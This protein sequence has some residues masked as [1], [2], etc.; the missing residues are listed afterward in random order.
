MPLGPMRTKAQKRAGMH[1]VMHEFKHGQLHSGSKTGPQV[2]NRKQAI[3]IGLS[4]T[5]QS[6]R[7]YAEGGIV[8]HDAD[9]DLPPVQDEA[10]LEQQI[11]YP[12]EYLQ[13]MDLL[14]KQARELDQNNLGDG[15]QPSSFFYRPNRERPVASAP[16]RPAL[17]Y[18]RSRR[19]RR[20]Q[21]GDIEELDDRSSLHGQGRGGVRHL[22]DGGGDGSGRRRWR[23]RLRR[24]HG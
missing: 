24:M 9:P 23:R 3:A 16:S 12:P 17:P 4:Q 13:T 5:G 6:R 10:R 14:Q 21:D 22:D 11:H 7:G 1:E 2:T 19:W 8:T 15:Y 18:P 20:T